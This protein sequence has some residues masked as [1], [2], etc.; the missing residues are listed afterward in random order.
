MTRWVRWVLGIAVGGILLALAVVTD[1]YWVKKLRVYPESTISMDQG[2]RLFRT[3]VFENHESEGIPYW[4]WKTLPELF[5]ED[6][7]PDYATVGFVREPGQ[8][9]PLGLNKSARLGIDWVTHNCALCHAG[10]YRAS[11]TAEPTIVMGMPNVTFRRQV[12]VEGLEKALISPRFTPETVLA[13]V[14]KHATLTD[15]E[16]GVYREWVGKLRARTEGYLRNVGTTRDWHPRHA[17]GAAEGFGAAKQ[18]A[19]IFDRTIGTADFPST[20]EQGKRTIGHWDGIS[21]STLERVVGSALA[22]GAQGSRIDMQQMLDLDHYTRL[23]VPPTYPLPVDAGRARQGKALYAARCGACHARSGSRVNTIVPLGEIG[24]DPN[25]QQSLEA[26][27]LWRI[28]LGTLPAPYPFQHWQAS[29]GYRSDFLEGVW[30]RGPYLHNGS[31]PTIRDLLSAARDRPK[32]FW[33]GS[34]ILD[35]TNMGFMSDQASDGNDFLYDTGLPGYANTGHEYGVDLSA[36]E[37]DALI[38]YLK[39]GEAG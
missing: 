37:K 28:K 19:F 21:T 9:L 7:A 3:A 32:T 33:R 27:F 24:T 36:V 22:I 20:W 26:S 29:N 1:W 38:E 30:L 10:A 35:T 23:L 34:N 13:T 15:G 5:P 18:Y 16:A 12:Y 39:T 31:V 25:R 14:A 11:A 8:D 4:I 17:P 2:E 6:I